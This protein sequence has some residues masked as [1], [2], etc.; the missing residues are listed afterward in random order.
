MQA[1]RNLA[2][3]L[4]T[5]G[6]VAV[7]I[8]WEEGPR[9]VRP[10]FVTRP[11]DADRL[12]F[13]ARCVQNLATYL[14]PRR[15]NIAAMGKPAVCVKGCDARAVAGLVR[16]SQIK[17]DD[18]VLIGLRCS[19][20][21]LE[22]NGPASAKAEGLSPRCAGCDALEPAATEHVVGETIPLGAVRGYDERLAELE[23]LPLEKRWAYWQEAFARCTRCNACRQVCPMCFC[24]QCVQDKTRPQW[25]ES[26]PHP[27]GN[28]AWHLTRAMH[29]AGRCSG[30]AECE[31]ACPAGIPLMLLNR[32]VT[33][34]VE[35]R[36]GY[37]ASS[38]PAVPCP[39]GTFRIDDRQEFIR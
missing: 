27:R 18:V 33:R 11:E 8:G 34:T 26:S 9:G 31:R 16:E 12:V 20:V 2:K 17:R 13:D 30:C 19:G 24:E 6:E 7:V 22:A 37:K 21:G 3:D 10:A 14:N 1:L 5:R 38:D 32:K 28:M 36:F 15:A 35:T 23:A 4:L 29:Q 39:V 25:V